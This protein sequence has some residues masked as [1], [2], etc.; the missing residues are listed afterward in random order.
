[1]LIVV[2]ALIAHQGR[3]LVCQRKRGQRM[4][5]MW[6]FPGGKVE[7]G[8]TPE[9]ALVRELREELGVNATVGREIFRARHWYAETRQPIELIFLSAIALPGEIQNLEFEQIAWRTPQSLPELNFLAA[10]KELIV[11][12]ASGEV[13]LGNRP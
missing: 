1:V 11:K 2:A 10:D 12:L 9:E 8:E 6:E 7:P 4:E 13:Q 3:I 5:M